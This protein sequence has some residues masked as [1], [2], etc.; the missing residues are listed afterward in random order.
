MEIA[1]WSLT[2]K[3]SSPSGLLRYDNELYAGTSK[4]MS[5]KR[6]RGQGNVL[7]TLAGYKRGDVTHITTHQLAFMSPCMQLKNSIV[8]VHDLIQ[9][10][11]FGLK[12]SVKEKWLLNEFTLPLDK[13]DRYITD[14]IST[15]NDL[16]RIYKIPEWKIS[17]VYLG[18]DHDTYFP[19]SQEECKIKFG[20]DPDK[21]YLLGV[22]SGM[23]WKN[24]VILDKLAYDYNVIDIGYG[25]GTF[26]TVSEIDMPYLYSACDAF[27]AP[28]L[29]EGFCLP[30]VEAMACGVPVIG[31][32]ATALPEVVGSG[33][34][35]VNPYN[36]EDWK[37]AVDKVLKYQDKWT[38][39]AITRA[40]FFS[41][42]KMC[43]ETMKIYKEF[44]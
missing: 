30:V 1:Q 29:H 6:Y 17:V 16:V 20:L 31:A 24:T 43:N 19:R 25:R 42:E 28:S 23:P 3:D 35:V 15:K 32:C 39:R 27:I 2:R 22:S 8:T 36:I 7:K 5:V 13:I 12:R 18:V 37:N 33:G 10:F 44:E 38:Q 9:Y 40:E 4:E 11:W 21:K 34:V 26:G 41:W 14:S